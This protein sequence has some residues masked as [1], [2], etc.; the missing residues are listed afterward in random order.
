M[1]MVRVYRYGLLAP[2]ENG[3]AVRDQMFLAHRYYN[4]LTEI[5]RG[6]RAAIRQVHSSVGDMSLFERELAAAESELGDAVDA[7]KRE[8]ARTRKRTETPEMRERI[9][10]ARALVSGARVKIREYRARVKENPEVVAQIEQIG[11]RSNELM[12]NAR[13]YSG[14][15][16]RGPHFGAWGTY[17]LAEAA[18]EQSR[19]MTPFYDDPGFRRW[20]GEGRVGAYTSGGVPV[21]DV[22]GPDAGA[23]RIERVDERAWHSESR[24]ERRRFSRTVV[25]LRLGTDAAGEVVWGAWPMVMHREIPAGGVIKN[26]V[27]SLRKIGPREEWSLLVTVDLPGEYRQ[28]ECGRGRVAVNFGWRVVGDRRVRVAV[29]VD[30]DGGSG[31]IEIEDG[32]FTGIEKADGLRS[33]RDKNLEELKGRLGAWLKGAPQDSPVVGR[34]KYLYALKSPEKLYRVARWWKENRFEGD[35][36]GYVML[37]KWRYNDF[38]LWSWEA[39]QRSKSLRSRK[40]CYRRSAKELTGRYAEIVLAPFD[41]RGVAK[42]AK[43]EEGSENETARVNRQRVAVSELEMQ[44]KNAAASS[45]CS[46]ILVDGKGATHICSECGSMEEFDASAHVKH[47][48]SACGAVWDQDENACRVFLKRSH[49]RGDDGGTPGGAR[50]K[51]NGSSLADK[52]EK[53]RERMARQREEKRVRKEGSRKSVDNAAE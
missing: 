38:H 18:A 45:G 30:E 49:E 48:C 43:P 46:L 29:F 50:G 51:E 41:K 32:F 1:K 8:R 4:T 15:A 26:S 24:A 19:K 28:R 11:E 3:A 40:D 33:I 42:R 35:E 9:K 7:Q 39:S 14:L 52:P 5:E 16:R 21:A 17:L 47:A 13:A 37:E 34:L 2:T 31:E 12:K 10:A 22:F 44:I 36:D 20:E 6:R 23:L 27:V 25:R 53:R